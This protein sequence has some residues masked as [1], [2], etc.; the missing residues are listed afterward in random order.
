MLLW[1]LFILVSFL[2]GLSLSLLL[3]YP[4][5]RVERALFAFVAGHAV[6][7]WLTVLIALYLASCSRRSIMLSASLCFLLAIL[8]LYVQRRDHGIS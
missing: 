3:H 2:L 7:L 1:L 4:F 5:H 8:L 6:S